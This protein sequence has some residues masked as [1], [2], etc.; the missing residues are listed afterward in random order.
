M[1]WL[2]INILTLHT[3]ASNPRT[4]NQLYEY[5]TIYSYSSAAQRISQNQSQTFLRLWMNIVKPKDK[6][7][8]ARRSSLPQNRSSCRTMKPRTAKMKFL[9]GRRGPAAQMLASSRQVPDLLT[10]F[11]P[12]EGFFM[13]FMVK[14]FVSYSCKFARRASARPPCSTRRGRS[15]QVVQ[16]SLFPL[17]LCG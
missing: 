11:A 7:V 9:R 8:Q 1:K 12:A 4:S 5:I 3:L 15:R 14:Q 17:C 2:P 6:K 16:I 13:N 10:G